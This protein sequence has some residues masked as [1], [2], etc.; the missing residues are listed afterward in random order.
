MQDKL[1][2][3]NKR[4]NQFDFDQFAHVS[5]DENL[6]ERGE[7]TDEQIIDTIIG[8]HNNDDDADND[9]ASKDSTPKLTLRAA[10]DALGTLRLF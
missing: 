10:N 1:S 7:I 3:L 2:Q 8:T 6:P 5:R 4:L 9:I